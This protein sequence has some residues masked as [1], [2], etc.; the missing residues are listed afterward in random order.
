MSKIIP[1]H[2]HR[3]GQ[4]ADPAGRGSGS[5]SGTAVT[6]SSFFDLHCST[7]R[8]YNGPSVSSQVSAILQEGSPFLVGEWLV[9]PTLNRLTRG[10]DSVQLESKAIDVLLCLVAHAG[11]VVSKDTLFD[12][13]WQ[14][15][16]V[17]DSTLTSRIGELRNALG[18]DAQSPRYIETIRKRGYRLIADVRAVTTPTETPLAI[19][20]APPSPEEEQNP[21]PGLAAFTEADADRFFGREA[22]AAALWR[23]I[24]AR[25]LLAVIG[26]S[27][28]GKSSLLRA[29]VVPRAPPGWRVVVFTPG[30]APVLSLARA[31]APDHSGDPAAMARLLGFNDADTALAVVARWR[32]QFKE[33][34][35]V[36]DQFEELFTLNPPAVQASF[37]AL[38]RRLV[39][40]AEVHVV[41]VMRDDYLYRCQQHEP[42]APIFKDLTPLPPPTP[43]GLRRA[44]KEPAARLLYRFSSE[45]LVDRMIAEVEGE[46]GALPLMAFAVHRLWEERDRDERLLTDEAYERIG[47]VAGALAK[48]AEATLDRIGAERLPIVRELFRNLVTAEGTRAVRETVELLSVFDDS[49]RESATAV[50]R[51]LIDA[52]LL[53][54]YRAQGD[55]ERPARHV[56]IIHESL[57]TSWPRLVRWQAQDAEG[58]LLRDQLR[59]A[60]HLWEEKGR[61]DDLLWSGAPYRE[62]AVWRERYPGGLTELEEAFAASMDVAANRRRRRRR[63]A[64]TIGVIV[65]AAVATALFT[66]WRSSV[67]ETRRAEARKLIAIGRVELDRNPAA[68]LAFARASLEVADSAEARMLAVQALWAGPPAFFVADAVQCLEAAFSPDGRRLACGGFSPD[69]TILRSDGVEPIRIRDLPEKLDMRGVAFTPSGDRLLSWLEGDPSIRIFGLSGEDLGILPGEASDLRVLDEDTVA[70]VGPFELGEIERAVRIWSLADRSSRLV[71]RWQPPSGFPSSLPGLPPAAIDLQLSWLAYGDDAAVHL[72]A[73]TGPDVG[74]ERALGNHPA[75]VTNL[76]FAPDG[77][78]LASADESGGFRVWPLA[79]DAAPRTLDAP[80]LSRYSRLSFDASGSKLGWGS[81]GGALVWSLDDPP[82]AAA[83]LLRVPGEFTFGAVGFDREA[84]WAAAG[85]DS[86]ELVLWSLTSAYPRVLRGQTQLVLDLVFTADSRFLASCGLDGARLWPLSPE[87]GRQRPIALGEEGYLCQGI[88]ADAT[89]QGLLVATVGSGAFVAYPDRAALLRLQGVP[90]RCLQPAALDTRLGLAA[91]ADGWAP[92]PGAL[93]VVELESGA[94]RSFPLRD[95]QSRDSVEGAL[96]SLG[97]G[98]D[99]SLMS[100]GNRGVYR[101]DLSTGE[102]TRINCEGKWSDVAL[103]RSGRTMI[104]VC[105]RFNPSGPVIVMDVATGAQH[106]VTSHERGVVAVAIDAAGERIATGDAKGVVRVGW[107][108]GEEPHL[109]IGHRELVNTLAFSPDGKW[110]ASASGSEILLWPMPDLTKPPL[111][112]LPYDE[113]LAKL[114][115]LTNLRAV[116]DPSSDTGWKVE[117]GPFPGWREVPTW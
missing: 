42:I 113:L 44:L 102:R 34:V 7:S 93:H 52:R 30:E 103:S 50:L 15:E 111:H 64:A 13:V 65:L 9:E 83:R 20:E 81:T 21:Y 67:R 88:A 19:P 25:R 40:A 75:R 11:Q 106:R 35:L 17:S 6:G 28:V 70:T 23:K 82:D 59:Q 56:E 53:T 63:L 46:R 45:L 16:F 33:A 97:F 115:S 74:R 58:A 3:P 8:S 26:P 86:S 4:G 90:P 91:A 43:D 104:A 109:L 79:G 18:D 114:Q 14:T 85:R 49:R 57:L 2:P 22:E 66:L 92:E 110:L 32:G 37:I 60:A 108:T 72:F 12:T 84:W 51:E 71:A 105:D 55:D 80:A 77:S 5:A 36:V 48:H 100:G 24:S 98:A 10:G 61:P 99:G 95:P 47:G 96:T 68:A 78:R 62:Y 89:S 29:G 101:W 117:I 94:T 27:G 54:G 1:F 31:L 73:I 116:R 107:T 38:L 87:D 112:T 41:L 39:D 69:V 76:A